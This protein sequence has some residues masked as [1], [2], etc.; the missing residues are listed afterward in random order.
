MT[1]NVDKRTLVKITRIA[2]AAR[3]LVDG[4][5]EL[6]QHAERNDM[7]DV[8]VIELDALIDEFEIISTNEMLFTLLSSDDGSEH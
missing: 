5:D 8:S 4:L 2:Y 1:P 6:L 3:I 7:H